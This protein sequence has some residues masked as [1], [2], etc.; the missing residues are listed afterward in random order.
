MTTKGT[1]LCPGPG[2]KCPRCRGSGYVQVRYTD[3]THAREEAPCPECAV[4]RPNIRELLED[5]ELAVRIAVGSHHK[6]C[7]CTSCDWQ[8]VAIHNYRGALLEKIKEADDAAND[9][10]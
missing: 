10:V 4:K 7:S 2:P 9:M 1:P 8:Q 3:H 5:D 6:G